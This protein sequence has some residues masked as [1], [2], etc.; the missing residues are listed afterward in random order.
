MNAN[1]RRAIVQ[2]AMVLTMAVSSM[3]AIPLV[4]K[5]AQ[6]RVEQA[7]KASPPGRAGT[8]AFTAAVYPSVFTVLGCAV[9]S[10]GVGF[11]VAKKLPPSKHQVRKVRR[12]PR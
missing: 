10:V 2:V 12:D 3:I 6:A 1:M 11:I 4:N 5:F 8:Q 9:L 7:V